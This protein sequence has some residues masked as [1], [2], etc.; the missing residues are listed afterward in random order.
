MSFETIDFEISDGCARLMLNRP[1]TLNCFNEAMHAEVRAA[2]DEAQSGGGCRA[3]LLT[4]AGRGFCAGQ[5]LG[6]RRREP[7]AEPVDLGESLETNY[8]PLIR[9]LR[10]LDMPVVCAVNGVAA[11]A[12]V[13]IALACDVVLGAR[14]AK[15]VMSFSRMGLVPDSGGTWM[16]PRL[17]GH[18]RASAL[19]MLGESVSS[20]QAERWGMIWRCVDDDR[21]EEEARTLCR[22]LATRPTRGLAMIRRALAET[23]SNSLDRQLD[24]EC[25]L[26]R[27]AGRTEDYREAVAAFL[28]KRDPTFK[29][30]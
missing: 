18:A 20:E 17:L 15:F 1:E 25:E 30:R 27:E 4:G 13:S 24:L 2:L 11:G 5:D 6:D 19:L 29:G 26:Q 3:L 9:R 22:H 16:L 8:N 28:E 7:D 10:S 21:L 12:G 23:W 14:S